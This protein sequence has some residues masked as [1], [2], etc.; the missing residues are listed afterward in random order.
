MALPEHYVAKRRVELQQ[1]IQQIDQQMGMLLA[2]RNLAQ[3]AMLELAD[4]EVASRTPDPPPADP[5]LAEAKKD[6]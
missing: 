5:P 1:L 4:V 2:Q 6:V 3:G